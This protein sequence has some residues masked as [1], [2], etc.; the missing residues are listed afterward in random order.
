MIKHICI[1]LLFAAS[2]AAAGPGGIVP[3]YILDSRSSAI[4]AVYGIPGALQLGA[5]L[6]LQFGVVSAA[7]GPSG[8]YALAIGVQQPPHAFL[9][10]SLSGTP[11]VT[12]LGVVADGT[13]ALAVNASG[14]AAVLYAG[15]NSAIRFVTG[16]PQL[17]VLSPSVSTSAL[18][19]PIAAAALDAA[20]GCAILG[21][22]ALETLCADGTS[23]RIL[24]AGLNVS[25][26]MLANKE[27]DLIFADPTAHQIVLVT[28]Y[29]QAAIVSV[30]AGSADGID[31]PLGL[32]SFSST[33][34][35]AAD[36]GAA[37]VFIIDPTGVAPL[38]SLD[39]NIAPTQLRSLADHSILL[40]NDASAMPFTVLDVQSMKTFFI[41]TTN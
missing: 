8:D 11:N 21:T 27:Q 40:L 38:T 30:L 10:Q 16:L 19:G 25:D 17:P 34:I 32:Q 22:G 14:S 3:G 15:D 24:P 36:S 20:G 37:K 18:A 2:M 4:R 29:A 7:F 1:S 33:R 13:R 23:Q 12:D 26:L 28:Q 41:P 6:D 35:L 9:I 5:P 39:T 31:T